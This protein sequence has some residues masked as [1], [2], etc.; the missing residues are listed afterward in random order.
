MRRLNCI[1]V[2]LTEEEISEIT[3]FVRNALHREWDSYTDKF[4][5]KTNLEDGLRLMDPNMYDFVEQ[6][7]KL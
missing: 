2:A 1:E 4:L 7:S 5:T 6:L 3:D